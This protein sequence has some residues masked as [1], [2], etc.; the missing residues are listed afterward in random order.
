MTSFDPYVYRVSEPRSGVAMPAASAGA[1]A[2][3]PVQQNVAVLVPISTVIDLETVS[4]STA[5]VAGVFYTRDYFLSHWTDSTIQRVHI[6][7]DV[8]AEQT[9]FSL[10]LVAKNGSEENDITGDRV[11]TVLPTD[12]DTVE[13]TFPHFTGALFMRVYTTSQV[14]RVF[15]TLEVLSSKVF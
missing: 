9:F 7:A 14:A 13:D 10:K 2:S 5:P 15:V 1:P 12:T 8:A 3:A 6:S 4:G 11:Y